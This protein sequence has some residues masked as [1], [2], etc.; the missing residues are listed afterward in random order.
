MKWEKTFTHRTIYS[1]VSCNQHGNRYK[2]TGTN[3]LSV[4]R[5]TA[6]T[7]DATDMSRLVLLSHH[8]D[9]P[10]RYDFDDHT[11]YIEVVSREKLS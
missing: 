5:M 10:V 4:C 8:L 2:A 11:A 6:D 7:T 9:C 1:Y 3:N